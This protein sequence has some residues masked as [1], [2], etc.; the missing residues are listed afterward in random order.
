MYTHNVYRVFI[1]N[2]WKANPAYPQGLEPDPTA[3]K[4]T[5]ARVGSEEEAQA[6]AKAYNASHKP[7][8]LARKAEYDEER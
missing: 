1:R 2:W 4:Y 8:R 6:I 3:R 7:G 5:L